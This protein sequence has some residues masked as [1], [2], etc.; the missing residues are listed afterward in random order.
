IRDGH[1]TGVQTCAL[2]ISISGERPYASAARAALQ[3]FRI[4]APSWRLDLDQA[5]ARM[6]LAEPARIDAASGA[7]LALSAHA[8]VSR[9]P[10][11]R[12]EERRV[13]KECRWRRGP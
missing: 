8:A 5:G 11:W 2:P 7:R 12:S 3:D 13:G 9:G 4:S 1:V 10:I 6:A